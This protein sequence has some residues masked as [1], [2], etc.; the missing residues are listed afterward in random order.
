[1]FVQGVGFVKYNITSKFRREIDL[2][3]WMRQKIKEYAKEKYN[4]ELEFKKIDE[5]QGDKDAG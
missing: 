2:E 3:E 1:M 5:S 4:I